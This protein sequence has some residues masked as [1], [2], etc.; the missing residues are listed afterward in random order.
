MSDADIA[1]AVLGGGVLCV[2]EFGWAILRARA[3]ATNAAE[4][5]QNRNSLREQQHGL[6]QTQRSGEHAAPHNT[7]RALLSLPLDLSSSTP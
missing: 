4:G 2:G 7:P 1:S 6:G 3:R 5:V